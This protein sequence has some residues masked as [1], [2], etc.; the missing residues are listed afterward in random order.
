[1]F[2]LHQRLAPAPIAMADLLL[3]AWVSQAIHAAAK[4]RIADAL[5]D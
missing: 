1:V 5:A 2:R 3:G 4:L